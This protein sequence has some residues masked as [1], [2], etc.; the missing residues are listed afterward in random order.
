[1]LGIPG[2]CLLF[3][4][5][6]IAQDK[7]EACNGYDIKVTSVK[8]CENSVIK[9]NPPITVTADNNCNL[10]FSGCSTVPK[11]ITFAKATYS[12]R[13]PPLP[14]MEGEVDICNAFTTPSIPQITTFLGVFNLPGKCPVPAKTYCADPKK[15][16]SISQYRN[17]MGLATGKVHGKINVK[18]DGGSSCAEFTFTITK[19]RSG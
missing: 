2:L 12:I 17:A 11:Q 3:F 18:H 15:P 19:A 16:I 14:D 8:T 13:K 10:F 6:C 9:F 7:T 5:F 4:V 1:M